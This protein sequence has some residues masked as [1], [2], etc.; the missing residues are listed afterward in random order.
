MQPQELEVCLVYRYTYI[1]RRYKATCYQ[2]LC[3]TWGEL[4]TTVELKPYCIT[5]IKWEII[6]H[7]LY[8][9][10][11]ERHFI[12]LRIATKLSLAPSQVIF[13]LLRHMTIINYRWSQQVPKWQPLRTLCTL[14]FLCAFVVI[15]PTVNSSQGGCVWG[16]QELFVPQTST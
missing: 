14:P 4:S 8:I 11:K 2:Y 16:F 3:T 7:C 9:L 13:Q 12:N 6:S 10:W 5:Y 15:L 1:N